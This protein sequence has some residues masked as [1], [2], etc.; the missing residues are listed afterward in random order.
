MVV[1]EA[2]VADE[3]P[4]P[5]E[6]GVVRRTDADRRLCIRLI[7]STRKLFVFCSIRIEQLVVLIRTRLSF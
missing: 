5:T 7:K 1:D 2:V 6:E 4:R 3:V